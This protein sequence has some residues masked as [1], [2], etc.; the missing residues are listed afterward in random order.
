MSWIK[1]DDAV[2]QSHFN[3]LEE[4]RQSGIVNMLGAAS[5]LRNAF[6]D[7]FEPKQGFHDGPAGAVLCRWMKLHD[8][9]ERVLAEKPA[10]PEER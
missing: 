1:G 4:L 5:Y 3:Y 2:E 6:P 7:D 8:D 10:V 9:P